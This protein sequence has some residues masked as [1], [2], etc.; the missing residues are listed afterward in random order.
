MSN[1]KV[2]IKIVAN[3]I[4]IAYYIHQMSGFCGLKKTGELL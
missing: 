3:A 2:F 1:L 4:A